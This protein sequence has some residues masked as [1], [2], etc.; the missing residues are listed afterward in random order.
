MVYTVVFRLLGPIFPSAEP[1]VRASSAPLGPV[2]P[3]PQPPRKPPK[4]PHQAVPQRLTPTPL[5]ASHLLACRH[6]A[7]GMPS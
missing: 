2:P 7:E 3:P 1:S 5:H 4:Q 6:D